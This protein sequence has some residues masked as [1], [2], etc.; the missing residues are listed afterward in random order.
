M[1]I[2]SSRVNNF[3]LKE[4]SSLTLPER[5]HSFQE[6]EFNLNVFVFILWNSFLFFVFLFVVI[7]ASGLCGK[8]KT[9]MRFVGGLFSSFES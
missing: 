9:G 6:T 1:T 8:D 7:K 3:I 5:N 2:G 4:Y